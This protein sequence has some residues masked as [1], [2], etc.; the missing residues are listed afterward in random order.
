MRGFLHFCRRIVVRCAPSG[1]L[2]VL[3]GCSLHIQPIPAK[4]VVLACGQVPRARWLAGARLYE[5][6]QPFL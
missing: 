5:V 4:F 1:I 2:Q 3:S 6:R